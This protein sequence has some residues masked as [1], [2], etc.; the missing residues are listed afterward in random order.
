MPSVIQDDLIIYLLHILK[1]KVEVENTDT[2]QSTS[3]DPQSFW[4][5]SVVS[6]MG[7]KALLRYEG[8][9]TDDSKDFWVNLAAEDVHPVGWCASKGKPLIP[10]RTIQVRR[11]RIVLELCFITEI[12]FSN[13]Y[14]GQVH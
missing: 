1:K 7:Y 14:E 10:P 4:V 13:S 5:A 12:H 3:N 2:R 6:L 8:F 11:R 9:G